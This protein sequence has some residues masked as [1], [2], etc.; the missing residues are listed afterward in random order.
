MSGQLVPQS[1][2]RANARRVLR[3]TPARLADSEHKVRREFWSK[4]KRAMGRLPFA[5]DLVALY[6]CATDP[7]TPTRAKALMFAALAYFIMPVD[8]IP[9]FVVFFGFTDDAAVLAMAIG[10]VRAYL[11]P[12][13]YEA[14]ERRLREMGAQAAAAEDA[15]AAGAP[16]GDPDAGPGAPHRH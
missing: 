12:R 6:Y 4:L 9:D 14:A 15:Q 1:A 3:D 5:T 7:A 10:L 11:A 16:D 8:L 2:L 13:H